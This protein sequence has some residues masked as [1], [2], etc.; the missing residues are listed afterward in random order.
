MIEDW[1]VEVEESDDS[2]QSEII[3][4]RKKKREILYVMD[5][6]SFHKSDLLKEN[7]LQNNNIQFLPPYSP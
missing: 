4:I 5:N 2:E 7:I 1:I 3:E 6:A